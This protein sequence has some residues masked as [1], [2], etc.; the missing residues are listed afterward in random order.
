MRN[1][2]H[3]IAMDASTANSFLSRPGGRRAGWQSDPALWAWVIV[4]LLALVPARAV[5]HVILA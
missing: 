4:A 3:V 2:P 5:L 1:S